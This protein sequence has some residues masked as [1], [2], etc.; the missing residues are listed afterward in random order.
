MGGCGGPSADRR[1]TRW[2]EFPCSWLIPPTE[3]RRPRPGALWG[4]PRGA[5][6]ASL[7]TGSA[8]LWCRQY[9]SGLTRRPADW[10]ATLGSLARHNG[11]SFKVTYSHLPLKNGDSAW[12]SGRPAV[13]PSSPSLRIRTAWLSGC[14]KSHYVP[15]RLSCRLGGVPERAWGRGAVP[16]SP[17]ILGASASWGAA[18]ITP[19][20][21][22]TWALH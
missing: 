13:R 1:G 2:P 21:S 10:E 14:V 18:H 5:A 22:G 11:K 7:R 15:A 6:R 17:L 8:P 19:P 4:R 12:C 16:G 3:Q 20:P 9:G